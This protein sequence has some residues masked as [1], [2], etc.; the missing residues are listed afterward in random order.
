MAQLAGKKTISVDE[1]SQEINL[2][3]YL[4]RE[5]TEQESQLFVELAVERNNSRRLVVR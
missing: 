1:M 5:A 4:G 2:R 3:R